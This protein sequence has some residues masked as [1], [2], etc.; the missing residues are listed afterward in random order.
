M[1]IIQR[2]KDRI[3]AL[4]LQYKVK[5]LFVFGSA[6]TSNFNSQ[7]DI[8]LLV[9]FNNVDPYEYAD[10]Y[11]D[12]KNAFENLFKRNV[13]LIEENAIRNPYFKESVNSTKQLIYG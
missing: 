8:D 10:N 9:D 2:H 7:S 5:T 1:N 4:C 3:I 6:V 12:L 11:F 13:D